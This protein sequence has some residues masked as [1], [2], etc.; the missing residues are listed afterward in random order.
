MGAQQHRSP[1]TASCRCGAVVFEAVG[2]PIVSAACY[3]ASCQEAGRRFAQLADAPPVLDAQ[4]GTG[5]ILH[6]K[7]RVRCL[8]GA[9][10]LEEHRLK[11]DSPTRRMVAACCHSPMFLEFSKGH[12]LSL[13]RDRIPEGAP[14]L[15][16]RVM[17]GERRDGTA[18]PGDIPSYKTHSGR[19]MWKLLGAWLAM[20]LRTPKAIEGMPA[21]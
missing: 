13:Y 11:P 14:P 2:A 1:L 3:C 18:L 7:D 12:W 10:R 5:F 16:M 20:G 21:A 8:K 6:R 17:T 4:G 9:E 19:F 15:E